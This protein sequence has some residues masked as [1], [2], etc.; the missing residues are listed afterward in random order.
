MTKQGDVSPH[1]IVE[2]TTETVGKLDASS[3][4]VGRVIKVIS[5]IAEQTNLLALNATIE[6]ARAG[7]Y[8]KG[9]AVVANEVKELAKETVRA[10][11]EITE[12]INVI[13]SDMDEA[14]VAIEK[15]RKI[16]TQVNEFQTIIAVAVQEQTVT[17]TEMGRHLNEAAGGTTEIANSISHS[18]EGVE[19]AVM[20]AARARELADE[21]LIIT[22]L[23]KTPVAKI[24]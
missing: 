23:P 6:A 10:T 12:Q 14:V 19:E 18:A 15:I 8:G 11:E 22:R 24:C 2:E 20:R 17:A 5:S 21:I 1:T 3:E 7:E 13:K 9:F 16:I 4:Q